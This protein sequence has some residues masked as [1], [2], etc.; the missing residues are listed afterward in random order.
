MRSF[1][2][3][4]LQHCNGSL[5]NIPWQGNSGL[6]PI[7]VYAT[8]LHPTTKYLGS[9]VLHTAGWIWDLNHR[10]GFQECIPEFTGGPVRFV[11]ASPSQMSGTGSI[12]VVPV[13]SPLS[14]WTNTASFMGCCLTSSS[15][16]YRTFTCRQ[17]AHHVS[18]GQK[19]RLSQD[20]C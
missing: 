12:P 4:V 13:S 18:H 17:R 15:W 3:Q 16:E 9:T 11:H 19:S 6:L 20:S 14:R 8:A 2:E 1:A 7:Q 5:R 10:V